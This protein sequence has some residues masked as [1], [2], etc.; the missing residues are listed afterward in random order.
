MTAY[1]LNDFAN[2]N[3]YIF[4]EFFALILTFILIYSIFKIFQAM[5]NK[6]KF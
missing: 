5:K 3:L 4:I 2:D 6:T 1:S